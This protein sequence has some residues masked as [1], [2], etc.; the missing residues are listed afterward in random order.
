MMSALKLNNHQSTPYFLYRKETQKLCSFQIVNERN[1]QNSSYGIATQ[2]IRFPYSEVYQSCRVWVHRQRCTERFGTCAIALVKAGS[3]LVNSWLHACCRL[4]AG[5]WHPFRESYRN[6]WHRCW[7][8]NLLCPQVRQRTVK[9]MT[10]CDQTG[11][12]VQRQR[13][14]WSYSIMSIR[15]SK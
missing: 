1:S 5:V 8:Q 9:G 6:Y 7:T 12:P 4:S 3:D 10:S 13:T 11:L 2:G 14:L 15:L